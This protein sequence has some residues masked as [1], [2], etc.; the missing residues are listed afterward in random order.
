MYVLRKILLLLYMYS[1]SYGAFNGGIRYVR[2]TTAAAT[3]D[4]FIWKLL[5]EIIFMRGARSIYMETVARNCF[6]QSSYIHLYGNCG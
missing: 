2:S 3:V 6:Y 4:P 1:E 5:L